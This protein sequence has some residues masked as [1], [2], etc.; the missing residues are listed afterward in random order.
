M[1]MT[2]RIAVYSTVGRAAATGALLAAT[3]ALATGCTDDPVPAA[4]SCASL[5]PQC[6]SVQM[7]CAESNGSAQCRPCAGGEYADNE[8]VCQPLAGTPLTHE[9]T[10][11]DIKAG[12]EIK[13][14]CQSWTLGNSEEIWV[15]SVEFS[16][17]ERSHHSIWT[18]VPEQLFAGPDGVWTCKD[19]N[20]NELVGTTAGGVLFA[21]STQSVHEVQRFPEGSA[22]RIPPYSKIVGDIHLLNTTTEDVVGGSATMTMYTITRPEVKVP[23]VPFEMAYRGLAIPPFA[24]SRFSASCELE[25]LFKNTADSPFD[26][27][28]HYILPHTHGYA[29][30][31]YMQVYGGPSDGASIIDVHGYAEE[32]RGRFYDTPIDL[33]GAKGI[34]FGCEY[35]N[36]TDQTLGWAYEQEMC[37]LL[38]FAESK[39]AFLSAVWE[40]SAAGNDGM[41]EFTGP[42]EHQAIAWDFDKPGG[43]PGE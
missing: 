3:L 6:L 33:T 31:L 12:E 11:F 16:Q 26:L 22:V 5:L 10:A 43:M 32:G 13:G 17:D 28:I 42:C 27:K 38:G 36:Q 37:Q 18:F 15:N 9:F 2:S 41:Q 30:R 20:Y 35:D 4:S 8:G 24:R 1:S 40:S 34:T 39:V 21:Q 23:L 19:R 29:T 14:L 25:A 7:T